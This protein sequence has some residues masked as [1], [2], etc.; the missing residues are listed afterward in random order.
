MEQNVQRVDRR[1][2]NSRRIDDATTPK[3]TTMSHITPAR[4]SADKA[5]KTVTAKDKAKGV[6][7]AVEAPKAKAPVAK[8][9]KAEAPVAN[10]FT[11]A[12]LCKAN[13]Q[14]PKAV[15]SKLRRLYAK[16]DGKLPQPVKDAKQRWTFT[17]AN[18]EAVLAMIASAG[19]DED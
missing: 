2:P 10:T 1:P 4:K 13:G 8:A 17:E 5:T 18:R 16:D 19:T 7:T 9:K 12:A 15:R 11:V 14:D 6:T 3:E